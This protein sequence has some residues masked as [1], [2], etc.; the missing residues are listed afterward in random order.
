MAVIL[1]TH[2]PFE[3]PFGQ[4]MVEAMTPLTRSINDEP[5]MLWKIWTEDA[6]GK[7]A[8]PA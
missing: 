5:G 3:G 8:G 4:T 1:Q 7:R 6:A 2:F